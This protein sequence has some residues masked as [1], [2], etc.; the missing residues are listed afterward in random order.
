ME[1]QV[2]FARFGRDDE[3]LGGLVDELELELEVEVSL[4][5]DSMDGCPNPNACFVQIPQCS[6]TKHVRSPIPPTFVT[7]FARQMT[8]LHTRCPVQC[9]SLPIYDPYDILCVIQ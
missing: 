8:L 1:G 5:P 6:R 3:E 2:R 7:R 4:H 9:T